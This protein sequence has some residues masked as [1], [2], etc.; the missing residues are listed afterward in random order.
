MYFRTTIFA[1]C[2]AALL[3]AGSAQAATLA[4]APLS[5]PSGLQTVTCH[6]VNAGTKTVTV[7]AFW[8]DDV[9][10]AASYANTSVGCTGPGP[11]TLAPGAGCSRQFGFP[12]ACAQPDACY[13][14][15]EI[16][17]NPKGVRGNFI[18]TVTGSTAVLTSEM[19]PK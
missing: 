18:A 1:A 14:S 13:C 4:A 12:S 16:K 5:H 9:E 8:I 2:A 7:Q 19:K 15:A 10:V 11:W 17:G 6:I 3:V